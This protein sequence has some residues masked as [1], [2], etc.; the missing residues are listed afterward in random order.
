YFAENSQALLVN[1]MVFIDGEER[2]RVDF[3][4]LRAYL[5]AVQLH[6][7]LAQN[8]NHTFH[9]LD[10]KAPMLPPKIRRQVVERFRQRLIALYNEVRPNVGEGA[11]IQFY[12]LRND[13]PQMADDV[14]GEVGVDDHHCPVCDDLFS[15]AAHGIHTCPFHGAVPAPAA[16]MAVH[17]GDIYPQV[18]AQ[19]ESGTPLVVKCF[20]NAHHEL[21][22]QKATLIN[23]ARNGSDHLDRVA[24]QDFADRWE[25]LTLFAYHD[26]LLRLQRAAGRH[27]PDL[28]IRKVCSTPDCG[29]LHLSAER[30]HDGVVHCPN[31]ELNYCFDCAL[32]EHRGQTCAQAQAARARGVRADYFNPEAQIRPCPYCG[33]PAGKNDACNSVMCA[34]CLNEWHF[35][36]GIP[37]GVYLAPGSSF[38]H[39]FNVEGMP[40]PPRKY[41]VPGDEDYVGE[42]QL[43]AFPAE[44]GEIRYPENI[45]RGANRFHE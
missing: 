3:N 8:I 31:C 43:S 24:A 21:F 10:R 32:R 29:V 2:N 16:G 11:L 30:N 9:T 19:I 12:L 36:R 20:D 42:H 27:E 41:R 18:K 34:V 7:E 39:D 13:L 22:L 23:A 44:Q 5:A 25:L 38:T 45:R 35:I 4:Q 6:H 33:T 28:L 37:R 1:L 40:V 26:E 14:G 17:G 15:V